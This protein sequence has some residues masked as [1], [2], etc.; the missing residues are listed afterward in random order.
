MSKY[1]FLDLCEEVLKLSDCACTPNEIWEKALKYG[2]DK[3]I[4]TSGK[5]PW[6]TIGARLYMDIKDNNETKFKQISIHPTLFG[7]KDKNYFDIKLEKQEEKKSFAEHDLHPV[8]VKYLCSNPH[9]LCF[10]ITSRIIANRLKA[11]L[12]KDIE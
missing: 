4:A 5:T 2:L 3:K 7:L 10:A 1:T 8:L 12:A 11:N 9:F 6:A